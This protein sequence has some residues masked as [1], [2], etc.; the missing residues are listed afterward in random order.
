MDCICINEKPN[1]DRKIEKGRRHAGYAK[2][3]KHLLKDGYISKDVIFDESVVNREKN[4]IINDSSN[5]SISLNVPYSLNRKN[6]WDTVSPISLNINALNSITDNVSVAVVEQ[7]TTIPDIGCQNKKT[8]KYLTEQCVTGITMSNEAGYI[9]VKGANSSSGANLSSLIENNK[10]TKKNNEI[11]N[12]ESADCDDSYNSN[13]CKAQIRYRINTSHKNNNYSVCKHFK[14]QLKAKKTTQK[15]S[16]SC[17]KKDNELDFDSTELISDDENF[18]TVNE[19]LLTSIP[20]ISQFLLSDF[21]TETPPVIIDVESVKNID[22]TTNSTEDKIKPKDLL[23]LPSELRISTIFDEIK[24]DTSKW[25]NFNFI[26]DINKLLDKNNYNMKWIDDDRTIILID[27]SGNIDLMHHIYKKMKFMIVIK[28]S[29][30]IKNTLKIIFNTNLKVTNI[31]K[32]NNVRRFIKN[33]ILSLKKNI[34]SIED[35]IESCINIGKEWLQINNEENKNGDEETVNWTEFEKNYN[36]EELSQ[37]VIPIDEYQLYEILENDITNIWE[38]S[39]SDSENSNWDIKSDDSFEKVSIDDLTNIDKIEESEFSLMKCNIC[40][41]SQSLDNTI[42]L[43]ECKHNFCKECLTENFYKQI[44]LDERSLNC[45]YCQK[46]VSLNIL[47]MIFPLPLISFYIHHEYSKKMKKQGFCTIYCIKCKDITTMN[48]QNHYSN[49]NCQKCNIFWC[50]LC[51]KAPHYPLTCKQSFEWKKR[52]EKNFEIMNVIDEKYCTNENCQVCT[53]HWCILCKGNSLYP[54]SSKQVFE[55]ENKYSDVLDFSNGRTYILKY[56][57]LLG[58][59]RYCKIEFCVF[60]KKTPHFSYDCDEFIK[61]KERCIKGEVNKNDKNEFENNKH[62]SLKF[63]VKIYDVHCL[64]FNF[65]QFDT[66]SRIWNKIRIQDSDETYL[67]LRK[68]LLYLIEYGYAWL[69]LNKNNKPENY[70][71]IKNILSGSFSYYKIVDGAIVNM[72]NE[73]IENK[74]QKIRQNINVILNEFSR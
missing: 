23:V 19:S 54:S 46:L 17:K 49:V 13:K 34:N 53:D 9:K 31:M 69:Y 55:N 48:L 44:R 2:L 35:F 37:N 20:K 8:K 1:I 66:L 16:K 28:N 70:T 30:D 27:L 22:E 68:T 29:Q 15:P 65:P 56:W 51:K 50:V 32:L 25:D 11:T 14:Q 59:C 73:N 39:L 43:N 21:I 63:F 42:I 58:K 67:Q 12:L 71:R 10:K 57:K 38:H 64:R 36:S 26:S 4:R 47:T 5:D 61:F 60:C 7:M 62:V 40:K 72:F 45:P 24:F 3:K 52:L 33:Q 18:D 6:R 74:L 41:T